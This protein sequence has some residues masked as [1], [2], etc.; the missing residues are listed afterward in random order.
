[1]KNSA[2]SESLQ[3]L[4]SSSTKR[5]G[6]IPRKPMHGFNTAGAPVEPLD[7]LGS[8]VVAGQL[9][10]LDR[11]V[12]G[13]TEGFVPFIA[14]GFGAFNQE[15]HEEAA[16]YLH[17]SV[18]EGEEK[19]EFLESLGEGLGVDIDQALT[20]EDVF[21]DQ[22]FWDI[23]SDT[24]QEDYQSFVSLKRDAETIMSEDYIS[25]KVGATE[26]LEAMEQHYDVD[27]PQEAVEAV[28]EFQVETGE[29]MRGP[30]MYIPAEI[31]VSKYLEEEHGVNHKL[32]PATEKIYDKKIAGF[33]DTTRMKQ[34]VKTHSQ[35]GSP[36]TANPYIAWD[37]TANRIFA[38]DT[39]EEVEE[40]MQQAPARYI[41][42]EKHPHNGNEGEVLNPILEKGLY[43]VE[44]LRMTDNAV[45]V[46]GREIGSGDE[47]L[48][49]VTEGGYDPG[50]LLEA[51]PDEEALE[52]VRDEL[53]D[54]YERLEEEIG[55]RGDIDA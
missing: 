51:E 31:A 27:V 33:H 45:Q 17:E 26:G 42:T 50:A 21:S 44:G 2:V 15:S 1:M 3:A 30:H 55:Y 25:G 46:N 28:A 23:F 49:Y 35:Q 52:N 48:E 34:P 6:D 4:L 36:A 54:M 22:R 9:Q 8:M 13:S 53:P 10:E 38:N 47:L 14:A 16:E 24:V 12:Y 41:A 19:A 5:Q 20:T 11:E 40:K 39:R 43:V 32:G 7:Q 18:K 37:P 29:Q